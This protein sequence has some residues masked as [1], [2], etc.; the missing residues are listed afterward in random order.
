MD[1]MTQ[2]ELDCVY[3]NHRLVLAEM[4]RRRNVLGEKV[5]NRDIFKWRRDYEYSPAQIDAMNAIIE[6]RL[7]AGQ[8]GK[9]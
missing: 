3:Y 7:E 1:E 9:G 5:R 6:K 4:Q 8:N 2:A